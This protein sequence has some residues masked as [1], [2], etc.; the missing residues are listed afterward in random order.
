MDL[1]DL[2]PD[3]LAELEAWIAVAESRGIELA[4]AFALATAD[5]DGAPSV[6]MVLARGLDERG[7][8]FYTNRLSRKGRDLAANPRAAATFHWAPLG[9]QVR[10][11][12]Q[13]RE[14]DEDESTA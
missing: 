6:R 2:G 7:L 11:A 9:R 3:P 14:I 8:A 4:T 13:V 5:S 12:G 1:V 10:L